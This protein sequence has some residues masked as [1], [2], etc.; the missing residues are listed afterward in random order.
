MKTTLLSLALL[1]G[2]FAGS[3]AAAPVTYQI[4][5]THTDVIAT[6]SHFG[7]SKPS[8]HI[9]GAQG[10]IVFDASNPEASRVSV[11]LAMTSVDS[12]V[13]KL[14]TH[15]AGADYFNTQAWPSAKFVSTQVLP[16]GD[17]Q[18]EIRGNLTLR[19]VTRPV[20]LQAHLN[21]TGIHPMTKLSTVGFNATATLK[22]SDFG[23]T[24]L[25]PA[26]SDNITLVITTE[27]SAAAVK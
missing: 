15:L 2:L 4:D 1:A 3:A 23:I 24:A 22:R 17:K 14:D 11:E 21:G 7:F 16:K 10:E 6:W 20:V 18:L 8:L 13:S 26:I 25:A 27:A 5:P 12:H 19:G 9:G